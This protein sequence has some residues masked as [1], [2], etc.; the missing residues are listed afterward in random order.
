MGEVRVVED[1][2]AKT[3]CNRILPFALAELSVLGIAEDPHGPVE[4]VQLLHIVAD[5]EADVAAWR[6]HVTETALH[7]G[8]ETT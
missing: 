6:E 5:L 2:A 3:S 4:V 8:D 7:E 1:G